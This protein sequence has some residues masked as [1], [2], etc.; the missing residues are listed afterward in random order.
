[1]S[2]RLQKNKESS[3]DEGEE[4]ED[5]RPK[6]E[7]MKKKGKATDISPN[8]QKPILMMSVADPTTTVVVAAAAF[9]SA[10]SLTGCTC[11]CVCHYHTPRPQFCVQH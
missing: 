9:A 7:G 5:C 11:M 2:G 3:D 6:R 10:L 8:D 1:M 4:E